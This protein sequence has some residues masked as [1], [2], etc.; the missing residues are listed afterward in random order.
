MSLVHGGASPTGL[1][2]F[3][4]SNERPPKIKDQKISSERVQK[5]GVREKRCVGLTIF[6]EGILKVSSGNASSAFSIKI[7]DIQTTRPSKLNDFVDHIFTFFGFEIEEI[8]LVSMAINAAMFSKGFPVSFVNE[9]VI[10]GKE[11]H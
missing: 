4:I 3:M 11:N 5:S 2:F 9:T 6:N 7:V 1:I 8:A 10:F